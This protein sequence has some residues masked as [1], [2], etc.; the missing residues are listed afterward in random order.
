[1]GDKVHFI[2]NGPVTDQLIAKGLVFGG[3]TTEEFKLSTGTWVTP[4][5][6]RNNLL[7][8]T[9]P[10]LGEV[11]IAGEGKDYI[12]VL[13]WPK[14]GIHKIGDDFIEELQKKIRGY[15]KVY[16]GSSMAVRRLI[17][18]KE[19][20]REINEKGVLNQKMALENHSH[21]VARSEERL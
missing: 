20:S 19:K 12:G 7:E 17:L 1:M 16:S 6:I 15:N 3:R 4:N 10:L 13:A 5:R 2:E 14:Q 9:R 18:M 8:T 11:A 21:R